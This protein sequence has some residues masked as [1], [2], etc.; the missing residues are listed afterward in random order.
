MTSS[1][2][3]S[4]N[5][6]QRKEIISSTLSFPV[7]GIGASAGGLQA[8][9]TFFAKMPANT[10]MAFVVILHLSPDHQSSADQIIQRVTQMPVRQVAQTLSIERNTV[11]VISPAH[12]LMMNDGYIT[13][14]PSSRP[15]GAQ[16]A[17]D[18]FFRDLADVHKERAFCVILSGTG[19]DGAVGLSRIKEQGGVTLVQSPEDA[20]FDGMPLA[21]IATQMVDVVLPVAEIPEKLVA[22]WK[23]SRAITLPTADPAIRTNPPITE[24]DA[25]ADEQHLLDI[26]HQLRAGTG[27]DFKH[28]KRATV[29]RRIERR[30]Q[31]T[32]QSDLGGY[33]D[34]LQSHPEETKAL[35]GDMLIGVTNF[36]R[37][38]DAFEALERSVV[39]KL[40]QSLQDTV[41]Q[42][43]EVRVW[44]AGCSTGEEAYSLA[45][46]MTE[47]MA[48]E[49]STA[50]LQ[51]FATDID[52][53]AIA[54]G[55]NGV[56]P[57]A[58]LTDV[59]TAR[60]RQN[61]TRE[62]HQYRIRKDLR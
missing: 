26:L 30:M 27:H 61:F 34:Y 39:P 49:R 7:V 58:I 3:S 24:R 59:P 8:L 55:R 38:G 62:N 21:A 28:Y 32:A 57:E 22:L 6:P 14:T 46:L 15:P 31:V 17:I 50:R 25:A 43:E 9:Q 35:L 36:F 2:K 18:L 41:P 52:E 23:N 40:I 47:H 45:I 42:R 5:V 13:A 19:S 33:Y 37:D 48:Q 11:Y 20:E 29:L 44:S 4:A 60:L 53:R 56:Y 1:T 51:V 12:Y 54:F 16:V 10:D